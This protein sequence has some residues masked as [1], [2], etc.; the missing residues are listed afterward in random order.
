[1]IMM[2]LRKK[3]KKM[4]AH[5]IWRMKLFQGN[6]ESVL[7]TLAPCGVSSWPVFARYEFRSF[8]ASAAIETGSCPSY[9]LDIVERL[10]F[11]LL[12]L[13]PFSRPFFSSST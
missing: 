8:S 7:D 6:M 12:S 9:A 2:M 11:G 1:M 4:N 13:G 5:G 10:Y 3:K